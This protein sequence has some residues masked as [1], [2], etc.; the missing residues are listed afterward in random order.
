MTPRSARGCTGGRARGCTGGRGTCSAHLPGVESGAFGVD[1]GIDTSNETPFSTGLHGREG[2][3]KCTS[4]RVTRPLLG[5]HAAFGVD[6]G[7][8]M[9]DSG[10]FGVDSGVTRP[11]LGPHA[12]GTTRC[13][14]E[15]VRFGSRSKIS[16]T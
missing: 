16:N 13:A 8:F 2:Y 7:A 9:V 14:P 3:V 4:S 6:S 12:A 15:A 5:P 1:S 10:A 11:L